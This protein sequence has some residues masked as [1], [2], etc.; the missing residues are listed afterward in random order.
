MPQYMKFEMR[1]FLNTNRAL[2]S[3]LTGSIFLSSTLELKNQPMYLCE[4]IV[5]FIT[6]N[7]AS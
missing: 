4:H 2:D 5:H 6:V 3:F 1:E 7:F